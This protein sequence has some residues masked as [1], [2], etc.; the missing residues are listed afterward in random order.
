MPQYARTLLGHAS[1][2]HGASP[3]TTE[4]D[5]EE[6]WVTQWVPLNLPNELAARP[7]DEIVYPVHHLS[8]TLY[9]T[10]DNILWAGKSGLMWVGKSGLNVHSRTVFSIIK[11]SF[12][13]INTRRCHLIK[14][15][16]LLD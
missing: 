3:R 15:C 5:S 2:K 4:T 11:R 16:T 1:H 9:F 13:C 7:S 10:C 8:W 6:N 12:V 14:L